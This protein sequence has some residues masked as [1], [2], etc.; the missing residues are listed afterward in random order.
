MNKHTNKELEKMRKRFVETF[1]AER[2]KS[3]QIH[4]YALGMG[5]TT[6]CRRLEYELSELGNNGGAN[7][8][9]YGVWYGELGRNT[10]IKYRATKKFGEGIVD[11]IEVAFNNIKNELVGRFS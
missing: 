8:Q 11:N 6:F 3:M 5:K 10:E 2:I 1:S 4:E 9:K 7:S